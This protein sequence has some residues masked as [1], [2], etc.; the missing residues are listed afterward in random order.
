MRGQ[1]IIGLGAGLLLLLALAP[2]QSAFAMPL[3][4]VDLDPATPDVQNALTVDAGTAFTI[5][6]VVSGTG[7]PIDALLFEMVYNDRAGTL[8]LA[9]GTG[10]PIAGSL[11]APPPTGPGTFGVLDTNSFS[12]V[13]PGSPLAAPTLSFAPTPGF[14]AQSGAYGM[15]LLGGPAVSGDFTLF[16][17]TFD[18]RSPGASAIAPSA[19]APGQGG[20]SFFGTPLAFE[21]AGATVTVL[22][23]GT[24]VPEPPVLALFLIG[25]LVSPRFVG[26]KIAPTTGV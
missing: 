5:D 1:T 9:G 7:A 23:S 18:A 3:V 20:I 24:P 13:A 14:A 15:L 12:P 26:R 10:L 17:L 22:D 6:L 11:A 2:L 8:G 16:S 21:S 25:L 19:G 4:S